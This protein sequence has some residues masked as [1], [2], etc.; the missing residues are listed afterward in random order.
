MVKLVSG[1][2]QWFAVGSILRSETHYLEFLSILNRSGP[3]FPAS[4]FV[5]VQPFGS[6]FRSNIASSPCLMEVKVLGTSTVVE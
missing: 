4:T 6:Q 2:L 5:L 3:Y 1:F